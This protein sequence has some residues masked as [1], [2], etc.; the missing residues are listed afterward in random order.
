MGR[1]ATAAAALLLVACKRDPDVAIYLKDAPTTGATDTGAADSEWPEAESVAD[2]CAEEEP[3][4]HIGPWADTFPVPGTAFEQGCTQPDELPCYPNEFP[5][6]PVSVS[7]LQAMVTEVSQELW[8]AVEGDN[9]SGHRDCGCNCPVEN[10]SW[11]EA[12]AFANALSEAQGKP[13]AYGIDGT[14]ITWDTESTGWRLPTESEWERMAK[15]DSDHLVAGGVDVGAAA[16][17]R[18]NAPDGPEP[19]GLKDPTE[20][21]LHDLNGN[22]WEWTWDWASTYTTATAHNPTGPSTGTVKVL[23]GGSYS[24]D[25]RVVRTSVRR[26]LPPGQ[27]V[28]SVGLRLVRGA[29]LEAP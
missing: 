13:L 17:Y 9:P 27:R 6:H 3:E 25:Y 29:H 19:V 12:V 21:G 18:E 2:A 14:D 15:G 8:L 20:H 1:V 26:E 11:Y 22:V 4:P 7:D 10:I 28:E 23:R 16:W 5:V 24:D